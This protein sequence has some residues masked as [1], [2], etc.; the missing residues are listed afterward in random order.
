V[1]G[2]LDDP[3]PVV[4]AAAGLALGEARKAE[5]LDP[6]RRRWGQEADPEV[7][8]P[9]VLAMAMLRTPESREALVGV[10]ASGKPAEAVEAIEALGIYKHDAAVRAQ[11]EAAAGARNDPSVSRAMRTAFPS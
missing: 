1:A 8:K 5:A 6:L 10:I 3:D 11:V 7:R 2:F 4:R 9:L